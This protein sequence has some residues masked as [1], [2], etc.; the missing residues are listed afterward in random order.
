MLVTE[1]EWNCCASPSEM[2]SDG[3]VD[4]FSFRKLGLC[5]WAVISKLQNFNMCEP[6]IDSYQV[7]E[8]KL[9]KLNPIPSWWPMPTEH[10]WPSDQ[11]KRLGRQAVHAIICEGILRFPPM[12]PR[13]LMSQVKL[14]LWYA[15]QAETYEITSI[16]TIV[17]KD[18]PPDH[19][20]NEV[21]NRVR[22]SQAAVVREIFGP[23]P[24]RAITC[25]PL[26]RTSTAV[27]IA[28]G[29]YDD[30]AFDRLPILADCL[31]DSGCEDAEILNH[32]RSDGPHVKGC[33]PLD[34]VLGKS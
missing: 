32:L 28:T 21:W 25:D 2:L 13:Q 11:F 14:G 24:F 23:V 22:H 31:Q 20:A 3:L 33:W 18:T 27:A 30:K 34:L 7:A 4:N 29:I 19:P 5:G 12:A 1:E 10:T 16:P 9:D 8:A 17:A 15:A 26:W 6:W